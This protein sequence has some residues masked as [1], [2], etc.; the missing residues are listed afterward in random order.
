ML[1]LVRHANTQP[2]PNRP[3]RAWPLTAEGVRRCYL[4]AQQIAGLGV[5]V[6][7]TSCYGKAVQTGE[8]LSAELNL[9][10]PTQL[11][12]FNE[13][14]R[15]TNAPF[16][17]DRQDFERAVKNFFAHPTR[18]SYGAE[19]AQT[20]LARFQAGIVSVTKKHPDQTLL[21]VSHG[22]SMAAYLAY[23]NGTDPF[24]MWQKIQQAGMPAYA[25]ISL[26][27]YKLIEFSPLTSNPTRI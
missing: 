6:I 11:C 9:P 18:L 24:A 21:I 23:I 27:A 1:I 15:S 5:D 13:H 12:A 2:D 25:Q 20:M 8:V 10:Q 19:T 4:L 7:Y 3:D 14:D 22:T 17:T 16:F 26:P